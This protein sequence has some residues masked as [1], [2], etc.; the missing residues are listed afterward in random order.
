MRKN[1]RGTVGEEGQEW[2]ERGKLRASR[3]R[4]KKEDE[5]GYYIS[6]ENRCLFTAHR[7]RGISGGMRKRRKA[8]GRKA[9]AEKAT[10]ADASMRYPPI[11]Y[12][13]RWSEWKMDGG[14]G[15]KEWKDGRKEE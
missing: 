15:G 1:R 7:G 10:E 4:G 2:H 6:N 8:I 9:E 3:G 14:E 5:E 11:R 13:R 12:K